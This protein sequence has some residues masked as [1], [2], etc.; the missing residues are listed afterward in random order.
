MNMREIHEYVHGMVNADVVNV[1]LTLVPSI[2]SSHP[3]KEMV[4]QMQMHVSVMG[5]DRD[6]RYFD[7]SM[8]SHEVIWDDDHEIK[9]MLKHMV[10]YMTRKMGNMIMRGKEKT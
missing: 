6:L 8:K 10:S 3:D 7:F 5:L 4:I 2:Y 9:E 1:G